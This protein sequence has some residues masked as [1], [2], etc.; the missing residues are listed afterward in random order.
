M[1]LVSLVAAPRPRRA[2]STSATH[3]NRAHVAI[4]D[5]T[6]VRH[7]RR[8]SPRGGLIDNRGHWTAADGFVPP[9]TCSIAGAASREAMDL[10][11]KLEK[12]APAAGGLVLPLLQS[13][14]DAA[15]ERSSLHQRRRYN[16]S[17]GPTAT[18]FAIA[19]TNTCGRNAKSGQG[20]GRAVRSTRV[21]QAVLTTKPA[22]GHREQL[23]FAPDGTTGA[24][25]RDRNTVRGSTASC[26]CTAVSHRGRG[27]DAT[28]STARYK[29][30]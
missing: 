14:R 21:P 13:R 1:S 11:R 28:R 12:D 5:C 8:D 24:G 3:D 27:A 26:S 4:G 30:N 16:A 18:T 19:R 2:P 6:G 17:K 25:L 23:A 29:R 10:L 20:G 7:V 9:A 15:R 22:R